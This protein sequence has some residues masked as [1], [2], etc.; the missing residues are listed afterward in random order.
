MLRRFIAVLALTAPLPASARAHEGGSVSVDPNLVVPGGTLNVTGKGLPKSAAVRITLR[1]ALATVAL[2]SPRT[3]QDGNV[4]LG[5]TVPATV[6]PGAY[7][8]VVLAADGDI[9]ARAD[10]E[11]HAAATAPPAMDHAGMEMP[12]PGSPGATAE[13]MQLDVANGRFEWIVAGS[14]IGL[15]AVLG[16]ILL[17]RSAS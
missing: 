12:S 14:L 10:L 5:V 17:R 8:L 1:S 6:R 7:E 13:P 11:V 3:D 16:G 15:S 2:A 4:S 9:V